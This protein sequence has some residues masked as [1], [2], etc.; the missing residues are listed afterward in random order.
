V[1]YQRVVKGH[2]GSVGRTAEFVVIYLVV[3]RLVEKGADVVVSLNFPVRDARV[4]DLRG[5]DGAAVMT[6]MESVEG[7]K[8]VE[9]V[10]RDI[11]SSFEILDWSLFDEDEE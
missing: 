2:Y 4:E 10:L 5:E 6:W 7:L 9:G 8:D 11:I 1:G 3:F